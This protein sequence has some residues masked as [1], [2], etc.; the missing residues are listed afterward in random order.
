M[1]GLR[2]VLHWAD[3]SLLWTTSENQACSLAALQPCSLE[4]PE[5]MRSVVAVSIMT[6]TA[7]KE[8]TKWSLLLIQKGINNN[9][10]ASAGQHR[11]VLMT[12]LSLTASREQKDIAGLGPTW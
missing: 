11:V 3:L 12:F 2:Q 7:I 4:H 8:K 1:C 10:A 5:G 9:W 6:V